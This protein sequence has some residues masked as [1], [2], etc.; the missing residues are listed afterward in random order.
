MS[1]PLHRDT[2]KKFIVENFDINTR[3]IDVGAGDGTYRE[4]LPDY[5]MDAVEV[6]TPYCVQYKLAD[7]YDRLFNENA[8]SFRYYRAYKLI[9]MG[10]VLQTMI[11][12]H[13]HKILRQ[14]VK[15]NSTAII[16]VPYLYEQGVCND[17]VYEEHLQPD[18]TH[19]VFMERYSIFEPVLLVKDD[20]C[21][22]YIINPPKS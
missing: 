11:V 19:E 9:I 15:N 18:L 3:I 14:V 20:V 1:Y 7:K 6:F 17:N 2:I 16:Q 22:V 10:D 8:K 12:E 21:G 5:R 13:A 4:L